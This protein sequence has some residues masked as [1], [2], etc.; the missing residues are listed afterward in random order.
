MKKICQ[1]ELPAPD[2]EGR[3]KDIDLLF[4]ERRCHEHGFSC[5][6]G[7]D[8]A[9]RGCLAGPVVAAAVILPENFCV[10][11]VTDS[12]LLKPARRKELDQ[13]IRQSSAIFSI[14]EV[15]AE[16]IDR[17]NILKA[18]LHAMCK[19][20]SGLGSEPDIVLVDGNQPIPLPIPQKT[21]VKGDRRSLSIAAA[22][23]L[24]KEYR[25]RLMKDYDR[26][27]PGYGFAAHNGYATRK[28]KEAIASLGPCPV[29]RKSFRGVREYVR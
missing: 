14:A 22:S 27:W 8:E 3:D 29:H 23:I 4:Y 10:E 7:V 5:V 1:M 9:G 19:A 18:A 11:G 28:H 15:S 26:L 21:I 20:V 12:K 13:H 24:A 2:R 6:A 16:E 25:D 17:T